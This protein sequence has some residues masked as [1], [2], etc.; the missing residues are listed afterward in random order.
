[1]V[2]LSGL[3]LSST[4][5]NP[6]STDTTPVANGFPNNVQPAPPVVV[7]MD[8][9]SA[10][11]AGDIMRVIAILGLDSSRMSPKER[12]AGA[13]AGSDG[14]SAGGGGGGGED[15]SSSNSNEKEEQ[16][17]SVNV[18]LSP[19]GLLPLH[20]AASRGHVDLVMLLV[21]RA[22][23]VVDLTDHENETALL[24]AAYHGHDDVVAFL[25]ERK[26]SPNH[27]DKDGWTALHNCASRGH[28]NGAHLLIEGGA[29][30][31]AQSNNGTTPLMS[32]SQKGYL[33]IVN[34]LL[35]AWANPLSKNNYGDSAYD[36][37]A[38]SEEAYI[39]EVLEDSEI[40]WIQRQHQQDD[41][42]TKSISPFTTT[43]HLHNTIIE[44]IEEY[45]RNSFFAPSKFTPDNLT[46]LDKQ[47]RS[48]WWNP[49]YMKPMTMREVFLPSMGLDGSTWFWMTDWKMDLRHP[50]VDF[51]EGWMYARNVDDDEGGWCCD[52]SGLGGGGIAGGIGGL[53]RKRRW[54]R[55]RRR[56]LVDG[57]VGAGGAS[58]TSHGGVERLSAV[59]AREMDYVGR[60]EDV[61]GSLKSALTK[62]PDMLSG[63]KEEVKRYEEAIQI[64][65]GGLKSDPLPDRKKKASETAMRYLARAEELTEAIA[66]M[67][68]GESE[69]AD[70]GSSGLSL[71]GTGLDSFGEGVKGEGDGGMRSGGSVVGSV[72]GADTQSSESGFGGGVG[73]GGEI[74]S[75]YRE[76][77]LASSGWRLVDGV[78]VVDEAAQSAEADALGLPRGAPIP[79][80]D[81]DQI[82]IPSSSEAVRYDVWA[83][84][85]AEAAIEESEEP[86]DIGSAGSKRLSRR[87]L[88][89]LSDDNLP[90]PGSPISGIT[91]GPRGGGDPTTMSVSVQRRSV[92]GGVEQLVP[93]NR[94]PLVPET[95]EV[96]VLTTPTHSQGSFPSPAV[97]IP[98]GEDGVMSPAG[99]N[100]GVGAGDSGGRYESGQG[101]L[102]VRVSGGG[103]VPRWTPARSPPA[104]WQPDGTAVGCGQCGKKFTLFVRRHHCRWCGR[105]FCDSCT[106][107]RLPLNSIRAPSTL[108]R[109]CDSC[110]D[111]LTGPDSPLAFGEEGHSTTSV[112]APS[113]SSST[114]SSS[115]SSFFARGESAAELASLQQSAANAISAFA[116][117]LAAATTTAWAGFASST[118]PNPPSPLRA[119]TARTGGGAN[120]TTTRSHISRN[121]SWLVDYE[122]QFGHLNDDGHSGDQR[123]PSIDGRSMTDSIMNECPVCQT[124]LDAFDDPEEAEGHVADCLRKVAVGR[125]VGM[126]ISGNRYIAIMLSTQITLTTIV[127]MSAA[128]V[129]ALPSNLEKRAAAGP[130]FPCMLLHCGLDLIECGIDQTC[131]N[132]LQ[133]VSGCSNAA[134]PTVCQVQCFGAYNSPH[135]TNINT[136]LFKNNCVPAPPQDPNAVCPT[137]RNL[138]T[139]QQSGMTIND[140]DGSWWILKGLSPTYDYFS[141]QQMKFTPVTQSLHR[142]D[143]YYQ[144]GGVAGTKVSY[145]ACNAT[146]IIDTQSNTPTIGQFNIDYSIFGGLG[147]DHWYILSR[148]HPDFALI[149]Y[150]GHSSLGLYTGGVVAARDPYA[151]IPEY[152]QQ[153]FADAIV[154]A[155]FDTPV[156]YDDYKA[157]SNVNCAVN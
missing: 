40:R 109:V 67:E 121:N 78:L 82:G 83:D 17:V 137:P 110:N 47:L 148:P 57:G 43:T 44:T 92:A 73:G 138:T 10:C 155:N 71:S 122:Q 123:S 62:A 84:E 131:R 16:G 39:C 134:N 153:A 13:S 25:L 113:L 157:V 77:F 14:K 80:G 142:Y 23:A 90:P 12:R 38:Q 24:K 128:L 88:E 127:A 59:R 49:K 85:E 11:L 15:G 98:R 124:S 26:A 52:V 105:V 96:N 60:A 33:D 100:S 1:M 68:K 4:L 35:N 141:C 95:T 69:S 3:S 140:L 149:W 103:V 81:P 45:Q 36:L 94:S 139:I 117:S 115:S 18:S 42:T 9:T 154:A 114:P 58:S 31:N 129:S 130:N 118:S 97:S 87:L 19:T 32:A 146:T 107:H 147:H 89:P 93:G 151:Q 53:V 144:P 2:D 125:G 120:A 150:C 34:L 74:A 6:N 70:D 112:G 48:A 8:L 136:C 46:S 27:K 106:N 51:V 61:L 22:G 111:Y 41:T 50:R 116:T 55:V 75:S 102:P 152:V 56:R 108:H 76:E 91:E 63:L 156:K 30:V 143:Y 132:G 5:S 37:A 28:V 133:C 66:A 126:V 65:L 135:L 104:L 119:G 20:C 29:D 101:S 64:L 145:I 21:D 7:P 99:N 54:I 86:D 72:V 79:L